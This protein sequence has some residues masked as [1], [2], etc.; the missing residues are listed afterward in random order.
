M[1]WLDLEH[2][3]VERGKGGSQALIWVIE[4]HQLTHRF[5][6]KTRSSVVNTLRWKGCSGGRLCVSSTDS[7]MEMARAEFRWK[8]RFDLTFKANTFL[9]SQYGKSVIF[10]FS[11]F[12][13]L[14]GDGVL[15][16]CQAGVQRCDLDSPQPPPPGFKQ[17]SCLSLPSSWDYRHA[18]PRPAN[19]CI[20]SRDGFHHVDQEGLDLLTLWSTHLS[21]PKCW[22]YRLGYLWVN[23]TTCFCLSRS[24]LIHD[25]Y[26]GS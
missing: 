9:K 23:S 19:F 4:C 7:R 20:F 5:A 15:L 10:F 25:V 17:F 24:S 2:K 26:W 14:F 18:P 1:I 13:F 22:D 3:G 6:G 11:L 21:L 8:A 12:V 16:R